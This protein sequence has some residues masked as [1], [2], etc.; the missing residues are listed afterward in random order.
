M[1]K[2][3]KIMLMPAVWAIAIAVA[4]IG[5]IV[6]SFSHFRAQ[7]VSGANDLASRA[8]DTQEKQHPVAAN[9]PAPALG[10]EQFKVSLTIL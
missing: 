7:N 1:S 4:S 5:M 2:A 6:A 3:P 10:A 9:S 8:K